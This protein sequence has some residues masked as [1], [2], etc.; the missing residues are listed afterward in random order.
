MRTSAARFASRAVGCADHVGHE[1][2]HVSAPLMPFCHPRADF[3]YFVSK[4]LLCRPCS[5][6]AA[7][8]LTTFA[9]GHQWATWPTYPW[10][11]CRSKGGG[12]PLGGWPIA[13]AVHTSRRRFWRRPGS[14]R[15]ASR[16]IMGALVA[17]PGR[18]VRHGFAMYSATAGALS[19]CGIPRRRR[20]R[21]ATHGR[22]P[23][24]CPDLWEELPAPPQPRAMA[25]WFPPGSPCGV[26][27]A[28][29]HS[30]RSLCNRRPCRTLPVARGAI[31]V[32]AR[33]TLQVSPPTPQKLD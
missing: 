15:A 10:N 12:G 1:M 16:S 26:P 21:G 13:R 2:G 27:A 14:P 8:R 17:P 23:V 7:S 29:R 5:Y 20:G 31:W 25:P 18:Q 19:S 9:A 24:C 11:R 28:M 6:I 32:L 4:H 3:F 33:R 30:G 22:H